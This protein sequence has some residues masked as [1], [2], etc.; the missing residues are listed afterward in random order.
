[1]EEEEYRKAKKRLFQQKIYSSMK[2]T[3]DEH[4]HIRVMQ[5]LTVAFNHVH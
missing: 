5:T 1:M 2:I 3:I 4:D